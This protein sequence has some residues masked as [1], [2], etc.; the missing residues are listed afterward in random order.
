VFVKGEAVTNTHRQTLEARLFDISLLSTVHENKLRHNSASYG[1]SIR[2]VPLADPP[3]LFQ[4]IQPSVDS[5]RVTPR[6][7]ISLKK[8]SPHSKRWARRCGV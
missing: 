1:R 8:E 2:V 5:Y 3:R 6:R 4:S 7:I